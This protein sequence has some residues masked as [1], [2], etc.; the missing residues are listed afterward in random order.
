[1]EVTSTG[2]LLAQVGL[3]QRARGCFKRNLSAVLNLFDLSTPSGVFNYIYINL[4][5]KKIIIIINIIILKSI[6]EFSRRFYHRNVRSRCAIFV[7]TNRT[8]GKPF[9]EPLVS[10][11]YYTA[12]VVST[13]NLP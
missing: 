7:P 11:R 2:K 9:A 4:H 1:M 5:A 6:A 8:R 10:E 3:I 12:V 13:G